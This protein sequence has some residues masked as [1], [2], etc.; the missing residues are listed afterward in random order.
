MINI[1]NIKKT[2]NNQVVLDINNLS[3]EEGK[4]YVV[5]GANGSGKSTLAKII[6]GLLLDDSD[7]AKNIVSDKDLGHKLNIGYLPQKPYIFDMSLE[8][9]IMIN[10]NNKDKCQ[11]MIDRFDISYL[12]GKNAKK[13][14]GGEQQ[15]MGL[16]RFMM[17]DYD[18]A[19]LD[20]PTS[21]MDN[22]SKINAL[23]IIKDYSKDKT[24]IMITH[25]TSN[26]NEIADYIIKLDCGKIIC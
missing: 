2:Y 20:E 23:K 8:K 13:M 9:N 16:A 18:L 7:K 21:A 6:S 24:I 17:Q 15:K 26:L 1:G 4:I 10:G 14:S 22:N 12:K 19:I 3:L 11:S 25:D 5:I